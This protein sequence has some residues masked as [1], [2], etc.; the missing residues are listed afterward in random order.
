VSNSRRIVDTWLPI[1]GWD[2]ETVWARIA[3]AGT[4]PHLSYRVGFAR[5]SCV[6]CIYSPRSALVRAARLHPELAAEYA[7]VE[8]RIGHRFRADVSMAEVI[9]E[10]VTDTSTGP[11][12]DWLD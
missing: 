6:F 3:A 8:A 5:A 7:A 12:A 9:A 4:R 11:V 10:A 2:L 1:H